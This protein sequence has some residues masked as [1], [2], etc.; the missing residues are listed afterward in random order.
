MDEYVKDILGKWELPELIA[1]FEEEEVNEKAF[2]CLTDDIIRELVP[3]LGKRAIFN[4]AYRAYREALDKQPDSSVVVKPNESVSLPDGECTS[5]VVIKLETAIGDLPENDTST[6]ESQVSLEDTFKLEPQIPEEVV[7]EEVQGSEHQQL[8]AASASSVDNEC[9]DTSNTPH[10]SLG[11]SGVEQSSMETETIEELSG[12]VS[13][14]SV[15]THN[16][17]TFQHKTVIDNAIT[18]TTT[19]HSVDADILI[20]TKESDHEGLDNVME[21]LVDVDSSDNVQTVGETFDIVEPSMS[22]VQQHERASTDSPITE[23]TE[24][25]YAEELEYH[26]S[27]NQIVEPVT[28]EPSSAQE[29]EDCRSAS[30]EYPL[31]DQCIDGSQT[32][33]ITFS[34]SELSDPAEEDLKSAECLRQLLSTSTSLGHLLGKQ[35]LTRSTRNALAEEI[36]DHLCTSNEGVLSN[37]LLRSWARAVELV[38]AQEVNQLYFRES[39]D[40]YSCGGKLV[41]CY[42]RRKQSGAD[43][44]NRETG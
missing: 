39:E 42:Q 29:Q 38:F 25:Q 19:E 34:I 24:S 17:E 44:V 9:I 37:E 2:K 27:D 1:T 10:G 22:N 8:E 28:D 20:D 4:K 43:T 31:L 26:E 3:K 40:G 5:V 23:I 36:V 16:I 41:Q 13:K 6:I 18:E 21:T 15:I 7:A 33:H 30:P 12:S 35:F 32:S 14:T 11:N